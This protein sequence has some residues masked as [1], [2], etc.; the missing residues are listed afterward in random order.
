MFSINVGT[1]N[2]SALR[3][4]LAFANGQRCGFNSCLPV[5]YNG[6]KADVFPL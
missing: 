2:L 1:F 6:T 5:K 4:N 3:G